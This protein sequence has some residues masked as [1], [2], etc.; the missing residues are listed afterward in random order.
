MEGKLVSGLQVIETLDR[1]KGLEQS[2]L[3][4]L[5]EKS[6]DEVSEEQKADASAEQPEEKDSEPSWEEQP[7]RDKLMTVLGYLRQQH[8][9][10]LHCGHQV[11][12][13]CL[14]SMRTFYFRHSMLFVPLTTMTRD[15]VRQA[16]ISSQ[17]S[18]SMAL[19][20]E[21]AHRNGSECPCCR[22]LL[23]RCK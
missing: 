2:F 10:C 7:V 3:W 21:G 5:P 19:H 17:C 20:N 8:F 14:S 15:R 18:L 6:E 4:L 13:A 9:Y 11:S 23:D 22:L 1:R 16:E 12:S